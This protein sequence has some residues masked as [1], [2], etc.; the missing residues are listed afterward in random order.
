MESAG[1]AF[2][3]PFEDEAFQRSLFAHRNRAAS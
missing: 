2:A 1:T 3:S